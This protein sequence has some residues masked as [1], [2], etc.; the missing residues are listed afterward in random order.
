MTASIKE[1]QTLYIPVGLGLAALLV[2]YLHSLMMDD[3]EKYRE[4]VLIVLEFGLV[5]GSFGG[6][7]ALVLSSIGYLVARKWAKLLHSTASFLITLALV[8]AALRVDAP[9]LI[10]MT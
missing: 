9:T 1:H 6:M 2:A 10:Y 5:I 3:I 8:V 7:L 4:S